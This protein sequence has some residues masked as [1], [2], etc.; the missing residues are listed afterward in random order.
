VP[1]FINKENRLALNGAFNFLS[2]RMDS[3]RGRTNWDA[4]FRMVGERREH[5]GDSCSQQ[6]V[7]QSM[8][9]SISDGAIETAAAPW[10]TYVA[11]HFK[12]S[13]L[14]EEWRDFAA[15]LINEEQVLARLGQHDFLRGDY[16]IK[17]PLPLASSIGLFVSQFEYTGIKDLIAK[18]SAIRATSSNIDH[19]TM[20]ERLLRDAVFPLPQRHL[21]A[22]LTIVREDIDYALRLT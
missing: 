1:V 9:N 18:L 17:F 16:L 15:G 8:S 21:R 3:F 12:P 13:S 4:A 11:L 10:I 14:P 7:F 5:F 19:L 2:E 22:L 20:C 6:L